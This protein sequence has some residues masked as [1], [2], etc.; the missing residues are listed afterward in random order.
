MPPHLDLRVRV[1]GELEVQRP[2]GSL[3]ALGEWRTGKTADLLRILALNNGRP[4]RLAS[5]IEKLWPNA[6]PD[7]ARASLRTAGSQIRRATRVNCIARQN[8]GMLLTGAWVDAELFL[9]HVRR[10]HEATQADD[11]VRV[12]DLSRAA[13]RLYRGDFRAHDDQSPWALAERD[14][15]SQSRRGM[16]CDAA[17]SAIRLGEFEEALRHADTAVRIDPSSEAAHRALMRGYAELG[18]T[19]SAL[20][21]F[22]ACRSYLAEELGADPSPQTRALHLRILRGGGA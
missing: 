10:V 4:V 14:H 20:R 7:R 19:A 21:A 11:H 8:G 3:V 22:E 9:D 15:L 13:E 2:D 18:E 16:L 17:E 12:L 5:V 1:L 6:S